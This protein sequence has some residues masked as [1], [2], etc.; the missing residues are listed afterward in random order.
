MLNRDQLAL[1]AFVQDF[2]PGLLAVPRRIRVYRGLADV[3]EHKELR[4][5]FVARAVILET[6]ER[7]CAALNLNFPPAT[8]EN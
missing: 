4:D 1:V 3:L 7:Q 6:A 8:A 2:A 5:T